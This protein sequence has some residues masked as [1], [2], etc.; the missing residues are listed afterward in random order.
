MAHERISENIFKINILSQAYIQSEHILVRDTINNT[1]DSVSISRGRKPLQKFIIDTDIINKFI[2]KAFFNEA[3]LFF[4]SENFSELEGCIITAIHWAGEAQ[5]EFDRD[6]A[7]LKYWTALEVIFSNK[8]EDITHALSKGI[9]ITLAF[10]NDHF[11]E[12]S[13][14]INI[15]KRISMLYDRRSKII[16]T[17]LR[18]TINE[19]EL[20]EICRYTSYVILSL[21][22]FRAQGY[23]ELKEIGREIE[24][25]YRIINQ[26]KIQIITELAEK[27]DKIL[28]E[29]SACDS[30]NTTAEKMII[31]AKT[32][33]YIEN[34]SEL[35]QEI[36]TNVIRQGAIKDLAKLLAHPS[37]PFLIMALENCQKKKV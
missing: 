21:F 17:G 33:E 20:S 24:R 1:I 31:A 13:E 22:H 8:K 30:I 28:E 2:E 10:S 23:T 4:N 36:T 12:V 34:S 16:H 9:S 3:I 27:I 37:A 29:T 5:N 15:Y 18:E 25:L 26:Q 7:F 14:V 19:L 11:I 6:I 35:M 32:I